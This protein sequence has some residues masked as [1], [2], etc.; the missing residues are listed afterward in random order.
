VVC[1]TTLPCEMLCIYSVC[2]T[3]NDVS[4]SMFILLFGVLANWY[5]LMAIAMSV[6]LSVCLSVVF[7]V[8][9]SL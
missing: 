3:F 9:L 7:T 6:C 5:M 1:V 8:V 4:V 2:F